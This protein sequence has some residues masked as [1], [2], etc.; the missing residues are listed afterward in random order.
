MQL[1]RFDE[2]GSDIHN[3]TRICIANSSHDSPEFIEGPVPKTIVPLDK[4]LGQVLMI[5]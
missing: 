1:G 4:G 2:L 3:I 5:G